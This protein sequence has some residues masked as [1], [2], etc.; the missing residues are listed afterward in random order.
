M[1]TVVS[2]PA[3][4]REALPS[5]ERRATREAPLFVV[6]LLAVAAVGALAFW[7][8]QRESRAALADFA[9]DQTTLADSV[10][11]ELSTRFASI[12]RD[13]LALAEGLDDGQRTP[14]T[15]LDG[16]VSYAIRPA[17]AAP[18]EA[19]NGNWILRLPAARGQELDLE[20]PPAKLFEQ[21]K[22][23]ERSGDVRV[24]VRASGSP[25]LHATDGRRV[26]CDA[27]QR[28]LERRLP[29]AWLDREEATV[30]GFPARRAAVGL[31]AVDAGPFGRWDVAV[32]ST[33]ER[34]RDRELRAA[35]RLVLG[36]L[37]A[38]GLVLA[39]GTAL[40]RRQRRALLLERELALSA[41]ARE[42]DAELARATRAAVMGTLAM[43]ITHEV[44]TPLGVIAGRA[45]QLGARSNG[46]ERASR[47]IRAIL[48]QTERI[49]RIIRGFLDLARGEQPDLRDTAPA[50]VLD[51]AVSLVNHRFT[52]ADVALIVDV[53]EALPTIHGDVPML[54]Q[55][56]V[57]LLLNACDACAPGGRVEARIR[58]EGDRV[59]FTVVD[60][61]VGIAPEAAAHAT[62][63]FFTTKAR[64][65]GTGL[66][67][68][69]ANEIVKMHRG[70]LSLRPASPRGT[71]ASVTIPTARVPVDVA[72]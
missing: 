2:P 35:F 17:D 58:G 62:E 9:D 27:V 56:L 33:A 6:M 5:Q 57:N 37:V 12:R 34:V 18:R 4:R 63:P 13:G 53:P 54:Q 38:A 61:G 19:K 28:A 65:H 51:G 59:A 31:A 71:C 29:S 43:G 50:A 70:T 11:A 42:R 55:V 16:Y 72:A 36:V 60:D 26:A 23:I 67:L 20:V 40:L 24:L 3:S 66:G 49:R 45:E 64:G 8:A 44:S 47:A 48:E 10:A 52:A 7:D 30:L 46:D 68:A 14:A 1:P 15:A 32:V 39:F 25:E 69:I 22:R 21:V 41:L